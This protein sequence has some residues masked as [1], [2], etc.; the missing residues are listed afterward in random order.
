MRY[1]ATE[2]HR[3]IVEYDPAC[4]VLFDRGEAAAVL[5]ISEA[6]VDHLVADGK[7]RGN[8][9]TFRTMSVRDYMRRRYELMVPP[10]Q[11]TVVVWPGYTR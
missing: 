10:K 5:Q 7:L 8:G 9:S 3:L 11:V 2:L 4:P 1:S 6:E